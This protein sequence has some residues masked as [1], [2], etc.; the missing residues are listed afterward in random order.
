[1]AITF[2]PMSEK[3]FNQY[4]EVKL[5]DY[6]NEHVKAGNWSR[7][8]ALENAKKQF[9]QLLPEGLHTKDQKLSTVMDGDEAVGILWL[10]VKS[11]ENDKR[12]FIY[13]IELDENQRGKGYGTAT[14]A[15]LEAY[16]KEEGITQIGLHVFAHNKSALALYQKMGFEAAGY[17]M[18]KEII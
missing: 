8:N 18:T 16:A 1:M 5:E 10:H 14:M 2:A 6:A 9:D 12:A 15:H 13:D 4:L 7:E 17:N 11:N 3:R